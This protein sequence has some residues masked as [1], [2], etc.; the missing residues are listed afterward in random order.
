MSAVTY[1]EVAAAVLARRTGADL[2]AD[3]GAAA[4]EH[5]GLSLFCRADWHLAKSNSLSISIIL[6]SPCGI[7]RPFSAHWLMAIVVAGTGHFELE[8]SLE[9][10]PDI[11]S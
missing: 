4:G 8:I 5:Q 9:P 10:R 11:A 3:L 7:E 6:H 1:R 2:G